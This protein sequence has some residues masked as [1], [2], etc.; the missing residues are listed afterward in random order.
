MTV[1]NKN[2]LT[3]ILHDGKCV[4]WFFRRRPGEVEAYDRN[5]NTLGIFASD[6][7]AVAAVL[8]RKAQPR[9]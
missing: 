8:T 6:D 4:G 9:P 7:E 2:P 3:S 1:A 5:E